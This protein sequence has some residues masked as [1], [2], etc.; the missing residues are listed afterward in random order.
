MFLV[1]SKC[2][3]RIPREGQRDAGPQDNPGGDKRDG[4]GSG[5]EHARHGEEV[6]KPGQTVRRFVEVSKEGEDNGGR[7]ANTH[8][9]HCVGTPDRVKRMEDVESYETAEQMVKQ[10]YRTL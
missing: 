3:H 10:E 4:K 8:E 7:F 5:K 1:P 9:E 2:A 6:A